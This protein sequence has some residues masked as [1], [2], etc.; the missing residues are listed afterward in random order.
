MFQVLVQDLESTGPEQISWRNYSKLWDNKYHYHLNY[1]YVAC[2]T[3]YNGNLT[4]EVYY[5]LENKMRE[6]NIIHR[7]SVPA[8]LDECNKVSVVKV[9]DGYKRFRYVLELFLRYFIL[10][11]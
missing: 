9:K 3:N 6:N 11:N 2:W 7:V 1:S 8:L 10:V 5:A 4:I